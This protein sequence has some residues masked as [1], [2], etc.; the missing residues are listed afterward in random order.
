MSEKNN[1]ISNQ[2]VEIRESI[3]RD[4]EDLP[5]VVYFP[6][7]FIHLGLPTVDAA[8]RRYERGTLGVRVRDI[9][10]RLAVLKVDLQLFLSDGLRQKQEKIRLG[11]PKN[12]H[13]RKGKAGR[14][15]AQIGGA[16]C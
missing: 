8:Y 5:G 15:V 6:I 9:G 3:R 2:S 16:T 14:K 10:G 1:S 12:P 13:G 7:L 11:K 4:L